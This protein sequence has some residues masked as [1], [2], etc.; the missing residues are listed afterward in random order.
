LGDDVSDEQPILDSSSRWLARVLPPCGLGGDADDSQILLHRE[1]VR[2]GTMTA[3]VLATV[4]AAIESNVNIL[5]SGGTSAGK[6]TLLNALAVFAE[7][8]S[9]CSSRTLRSSRSIAQSGATA[10]RRLNSRR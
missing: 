5:I 7:R 4:Q 9:S 6:T 1:L 8:R 2:I 10:A 3:D